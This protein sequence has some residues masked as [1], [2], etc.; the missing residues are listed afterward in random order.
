[1]SLQIFHEIFSHSEVNI[2]HAPGTETFSH[3]M[4]SIVRDVKLVFSSSYEA[5]QVLKRLPMRRWLRKTA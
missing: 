4:K 2:K 3:F 5:E 1:M